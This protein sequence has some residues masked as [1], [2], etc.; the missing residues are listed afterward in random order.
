MA[1]R[2]VIARSKTL[3]GPNTIFVKCFYSFIVLGFVELLD[4]VVYELSIFTFFFELLV[5]LAQVLTSLILSKNQPFSRQLNCAAIS[6]EQAG[7]EACTY[8]AAK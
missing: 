5:L 8:V 7:E 1:T 2:L 4:V 6:P 3:W